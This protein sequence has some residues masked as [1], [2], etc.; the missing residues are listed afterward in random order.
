MRILVTKLGEELIKSIAEENKLNSASKTK[1]KFNDTNKSNKS[2]MSNHLRNKS[3]DSSHGKTTNSKFRGDLFNKLDYDQKLTSEDIV[4]S[5]VISIKQK[6]LNIPKNITDRYNSTSDSKTNFILPTLTLPKFKEKNSNNFNMTGSVISNN[7]NFN[8][9]TN[10]SQNRNDLT[11]RDIL[12]DNTYLNLKTKLEKEKKLK[13]RLSRIDENQF[14]TIFGQKTK[15]EKLDDML[16]KNINTDKINLIKYLNEKNNISDVLIKKLSEY[17]EDKINKVNKICQIVF[18]NEERS[19]IYK[20]RIKERI[21]VIQ[22]KE[23][24]EYKTC[25]ESLGDGLNEVSDIFKEYKK[26][27]NRREKYRD[28][29][30]ETVNKFWR[31]YQISRYEKKRIMKD[32]QSNFGDF[33]N[34]NYNASPSLKNSDHLN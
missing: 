13:D 6:K 4:S 33:F 18:Y 24:T 3:R 22:N 29:H 5:K 9:T 26:P 34:K 1:Q 7:N 20:E 31:K 25:I 32:T 12:P 11:F 28:I 19:K 10:F 14:R 16:K 8:T 30:Y 17:S 27:E 23:K 21:N 15:P 2:F